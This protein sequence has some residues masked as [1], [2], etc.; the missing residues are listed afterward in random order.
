MFIDGQLWRLHRMRC[1]IDMT[2]SNDAF[3]APIQVVEILQDLFETERDVANKRCALLLEVAMLRSA[4][5][6]R[7]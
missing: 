4:N 1:K 5:R 3:Q 2:H 7:R 6:A